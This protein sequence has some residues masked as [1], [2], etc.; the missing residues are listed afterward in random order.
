[1]CVQ[2]QGIQTT[3][4]HASDREYYTDHCAILEG[5]F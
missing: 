4:I 1:M 3:H 5:N 2:S